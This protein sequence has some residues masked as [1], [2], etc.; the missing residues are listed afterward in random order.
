M[1]RRSF[2]CWSVFLAA[3]LL[4]AGILTALAAFAPLSAVAAVDEGGRVPYRFSVDD[5][6]GHG[7]SGSMIGVIRDMQLPLGQSLVAQGWM[8]TDEGVAS[9]QYL[10]IPSGGGYVEWKTPDKTE[11][12]PRPD[13]AAAGIPHASGHST[14]GFRLTI[15]PPTGL[16]EGVYDVYIRAVDGMGIPC[17]MVAILGLRYGEP[18]L[19]DGSSLRISIPRL[20]REGEAA[21]MGAAT[22]SSTHVTLSDEG[23]VRLGKINLAAFA[24]LR[25]TYVAQNADRALGE[26][27]RPVLGLKSS[28]EHGYGRAG[29][30]YN[31]TDSLIYAALDTPDGQGTLE[32][33]LTEL[34]HYGDVWLTGYLNGDV[35]VTEIEFIYTGCVTDRVAAKIYLSGD[36]VGSY[37]GGYNRTTATGVTDPSL[38]EV[39]R[40]EVQE[41]TNDPFVQFHAGTLLADHGIKLDADEYKYMVLLYRA[42]KSNNSGRMNLYLCSGL[43]TGATEACNQGEI[44]ETDGEWHYLLVDL[45]Q[46]EN[47]EGIIHGWR[48]DYVSADSDPGDGVEFATVQFF[49]TPEGARKA[50]AQDPLKQPPY[51]SGDP[52]VLR[53]MSEE[54]MTEK[55]PYVI[56]DEDSYVVTDVVTEAATEPESHTSSDTTLHTQPQGS[57]PSVPSGTSESGTQAPRR[58]CA[59]AP[60]PRAAT[61]LLAAPLPLIMKKNAKENYHEN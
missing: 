36:L 32:I 26:N 15:D 47:W 13:L 16:A 28:G 56:P 6:N 48:F 20:Q 43:I 61:L 52:A 33:D 34:N 44:L 29:E 12:S 9:Y 46:K 38:G 59:S 50:A 60:A 17:D 5:L 3:C 41:A 42:E 14:A 24:R 39:L 25:I 45:S 31:M 53:D 49:R 30:A 21:V 2:R 54:S 7:V 40:L 11:I 35:T 1:K 8:A 19:D 27:R 51:R 10:W 58:G 23:R 37:F 57:A 22:V 18:D 4:T 55:Q